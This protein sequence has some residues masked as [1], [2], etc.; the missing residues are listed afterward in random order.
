MLHYAYKWFLLEIDAYIAVLTELRR[1]L[2]N[3]FTAIS[4]GLVRLFLLLLKRT[5]SIVKNWFKENHI[6]DWLKTVL[7]GAYFIVFEDL[8]LF[9]YVLHFFRA[10]LTLVS[11]FTDQ[12][13]KNLVEVTKFLYAL[14]KIFIS[15]LMLT[16]MLVLMAHGLAPLATLSYQAIKILFR[17]YTFFRFAI[18]AIT[19]GFSYY[20]LKTCHNDSDHDWLKANYQGNVKKHFEILVVA[21]PITVLLTLVSV[22]IVAGSWFW[23]MLG[24]ASL[25]L[26]FDMAKA[27]YYHIYRFKIPE[28]E[29]A[30]LAQQNPFINVLMNDYYYRKCRSGRLEIDN[31]ESNRIYLLKE[32]V[33][34]ISQLQAKLAASRFGFFSERSKLEK[35]IEGLKQVA[36]DLLMDDYKKNEKLRENLVN[37]LH[38]DYKSFIASSNVQGLI[39][40]EQIE[41]LINEFRD[42]SDGSIFDELMHARDR[43]KKKFSQKDMTYSQP[44]KQSFF[45]SKGDCEDILNACEVFKDLQQKTKETD[46]DT[47]A[48]VTSLE[49][50]DASLALASRFMLV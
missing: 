23:F 46:M 48:P 13:N 16:F 5:V 1:Q 18:S 14:F 22:G 10:F 36:S 2:S 19:L 39:P 42:H 4:I 20:Q 47:N 28:P 29:V 49:N 30:M 11:Y 27:I 26:L 37:A 6:H 40:N 7:H 34:K 31:I 9:L 41:N 33:V 24:L 17:I 15:V 45:K 43:F 32:I 8:Y 50:T 21:I 3:A 35:K 44:F 25:F 38:K 12:D